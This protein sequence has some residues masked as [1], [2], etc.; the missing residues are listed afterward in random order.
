M[1]SRATIVY[2]GLYVDGFEKILGN[3]D[4]ETKLL[5]Y[6]SEHG[7]N[8]LSL[9]DL[10]KI[11]NK[12]DITHAASSELLSR[13]ISKARMDYHIPHITAIAENYLFFANVISVYNRLAAKEAKF[14][15]YNLEFEFWTVSPKSI[16]C[17]TYLQPLG[18]DC[19]QAGAFDFFLS[20]LKQ[21][22]DLAQKDKCLTEVYVGH[23]D[24]F[25]AKNI[26][27]YSDRI[28][29]SAYLADINHLAPYVSAKLQLFEYA[30]KK[31][32]VLIFQ[33]SEKFFGIQ[34]K[35]SSGIEFFDRFTGNLKRQP[36]GKYIAGVQ[37]FKYSLL[38]K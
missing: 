24:E 4:A 18:Y 13:F 29:V 27:E 14:D 20:E 33:A 32:I 22:H 2:K 37:W 3:P 31:D 9:Y 1:Y 16:Y 35:N 28:L 12:Y 19:T 30:D 36:H 25:H 6:A 5:R 7:F 23:F 11:H 34:L 15:T 10:N 17:K 38:P 26:S 21:L 8:T